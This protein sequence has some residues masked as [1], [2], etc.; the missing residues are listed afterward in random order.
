MLLM[1]SFEKLLVKKFDK[2]VTVI[3]FLHY[4]VT[5]SFF[6]RFLKFHKIII[7]SILF[8]NYF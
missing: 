6:L 8:K 4:T 1:Y 5:Q 2:E 3:V 7:I